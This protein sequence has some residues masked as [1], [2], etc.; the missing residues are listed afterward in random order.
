MS[1]IS[2]AARPLR[3]SENAITSVGPSTPRW[4]RLSCAIARADT[5]AIEMRAARTRSAASTAVA[6]ER[7]LAAGMGR[8]TRL[9]DTATASV[10]PG[11][12]SRRARRAASRRGRRR[13]LGRHSAGGRGVVDPMVIHADEDAGELL[14]HHLQLLERER[15]LAELPL[16]DALPHDVINDLANLLRRRVV[17]HVRGR[18]DTIGEHAD[19]RFG[20]LG[21]RA[22]I[23]EVRRIHAI[24][25]ALARFLQ[26]IR[27][28]PGAVVLRDE[29][30][31][32]DGQ[33]VFLRELD[34]FADV[35]A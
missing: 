20:G 4:S 32:P 14:L 9:A 26:E 21:N 1:P 28:A 13:E 19:R 8:R 2:G 29:G 30:L 10:T 35:I 17:Q 12:S 11:R 23:L 16:L 34:A 7:T 5:N 6:T 18:L 22:G 27:D 15:C 3:W 31:Q 33:A 24:A 25:V